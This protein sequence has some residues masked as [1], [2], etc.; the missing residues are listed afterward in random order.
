M[1]RICDRIYIIDL[2]GEG[3]GTRREENVFAIQTPVAIF[4]GYRKQKSSMDTPAIIRYIRIKGTR[5]E[6]L[7]KLETI[8]SS[9]RLKWQPISNGWQDSFKPKIKNEFTLWPQ[10]TDLF[11]WQNNG[12]QCKRTWVIGP[13]E[14]VLVARWQALLASSNRSYAMRESGDRTIDLP[15]NDLLF[16]DVKLPAI[17]TLKN[18]SHQSIIRYSHRSFDRQYLLADN[19]L[20]SRPRPNLWQTHNENQIYFATLFSYPLEDGPAITVCPNIPD[21]DYFR[22]SAGAKVVMPLYRNVEATDP[23]ILPGLYVAGFLMLRSRH[24]TEGRRK[25]D[26]PCRLSSSRQHRHD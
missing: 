3:H 9:E 4:I 14:E 6:K 2:G 18:E 11:P 8:Y 1:R 25:S 20:I 21:L 19:R 12:V 10:I 5:E 24:Y 23:N 16:P 7:Q 15:Q 22:G 17:K 13:S 26:L